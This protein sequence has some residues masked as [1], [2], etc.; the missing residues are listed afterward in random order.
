ME[1]L[2]TL[3]CQQ[4][5][6][7]LYYVTKIK[8]LPYVLLPHLTVSTA[9]A[10]SNLEAFHAITFAAVEITNGSEAPFQIDSVLTA[11]VAHMGPVYIEVAED[12][13]RATCDHGPLSIPLNTERYVGI[14]K[15]K[16][17]PL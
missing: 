3:T 10:D 16:T 14:E 4:V 15:K 5:F 6:P 7:I 12:V 11:A 1:E 8:Y 2:V 13:W 9:N 17:V